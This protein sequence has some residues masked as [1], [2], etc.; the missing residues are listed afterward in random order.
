[1]S[2]RKDRDERIVN[3]KNGSWGSSSQDLVRLSVI[4]FKHS[5]D[6]AEQFN[7]NVSIYTLAG[8]PVLFSA[9]RALLI[10]ANAGM[11]GDLGVT[12]NI[13]QLNK[14]SEIKFLSNNYSID[15]GLQQELKLA[16][17][18]RN[19]IAHPTHLP[20]GTKSGTPEYLSVLRERELLEEGIWLSQMT[21]HKLYLW[22]AEI[23]E[24]V[25]GIVLSHH[26]RDEDQMH[27]HLRSWSKYRNYK[28]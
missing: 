13:E 12:N 26:Y 4:L 7:Q 22:V 1:M 15:S 23:L 25:A 18:V 10:E 11:Y 21:S 16:Y 20:T 6:Y 24:K 27:S 28:L 14:C 9:L 3:P 17:E 2:G 8:I 5:K 19:E